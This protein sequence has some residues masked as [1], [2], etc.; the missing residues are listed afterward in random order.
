[1]L[2]SA[3][4]RRAEL[5]ADGKATVFKELDF[6]KPLPAADDDAVKDSVV[7]LYHRLLAREPLAEEVEVVASLADKPEADDEDPLSAQ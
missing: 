7:E 3:C 4:S 2:L 6:D 1:M 5:D